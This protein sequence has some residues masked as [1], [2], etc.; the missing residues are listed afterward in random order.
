[1]SL[2]AGVRGQA[3]FVR[4]RILIDTRGW[5]DPAESIPCLPVLLDA[6]WR[7]RRVRFVYERVLSEPSER[8]A[9][10]L[11]LVARGSF[12]YWIARGI[13]PIAEEPRTYRVSRIREAT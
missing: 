7:E 6:L 1:A 9:D 8:V 2:P 4:Q 5:R 11:G 12:W 13:P 10:P 3:E